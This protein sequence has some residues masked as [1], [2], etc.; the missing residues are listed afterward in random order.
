MYW[1]TKFLGMWCIHFAFLFKSV[2]L[3]MIWNICM[4]LS[5]CT[6]LCHIRAILFCFWKD[7]FHGWKSLND[8][9]SERPNSVSKKNGNPMGESPQMAPC[10]S[11]D[12]MAIPWVE[13]RKRPYVYVIMMERHPYF[14]WLHSDFGHMLSGIQ[15]NSVSVLCIFCYCLT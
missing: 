9:N 2:L 7:R 4:G 13:V 15:A 12:R 11:F 14:V 5:S 6:V 10:N 8:A 3:A 1:G